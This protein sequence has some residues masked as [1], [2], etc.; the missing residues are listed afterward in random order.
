MAL[1]RRKV[2]HRGSANVLATLSVTKDG[3]DEQVSSGDLNA[4]P[5]IDTDASNFQSMLAAQHAALNTWYTAWRG[6]DPVEPPDPAYLGVFGTVAAFKTNLKNTGSIPRLARN[7]YTS[8]SM[9]AMAY[10]ELY[11]IGLAL[12][13]DAPGLTTVAMNGLA[14]TIELI[15]SVSQTMCTVTVRDLHNQDNTIPMSDASTAI[16]NTQAAWNG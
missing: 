13:S 8:L 10:E 1:D 9:I 7:D 2:I 14:A 4:W 6:T 11:T 5:S 3:I 15:K 16:T 12:A